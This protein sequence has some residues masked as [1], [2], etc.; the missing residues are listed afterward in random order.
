[1]SSRGVA[2]AAAFFAVAGA[3][4]ACSG[5]AQAVGSKND[6]PTAAAEPARFIVQFHGIADPSD[7]QFIRE[8][9]KA[10]GAPLTYVRPM[11]GDFHLL[12]SVIPSARLPTLL[13]RLRARPE[14]SHVELDMP[15]RRQ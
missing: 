8:L 5:A 1:M 6:T 11:S 2:L 7:P 12:R 9:S 13:E 3:V 4:A 10:V 15:V 14:I